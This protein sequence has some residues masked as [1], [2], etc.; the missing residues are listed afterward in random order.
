AAAVAYIAFNN[1]SQDAIDAANKVSA[2]TI[3]SQGETLRA[4]EG[5]LAIAK[6]AENSAVAHEQ[7]KG[8]LE[9]LD[10]AT[11][12]V[13]SSFKDEKAQLALINEEL[14][15]RVKNGK[16]V[17]EDQFRVLALGAAETVG[18]IKELKESI[19]SFQEEIQRI[20]EIRQTPSGSL[21]DFGSGDDIGKLSR[22][23]ADADAK[24]AQFQDSLKKIQTNLITN[25][26]A[27]KLNRDQFIELA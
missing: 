23:L 2:E 4:N 10:P 12:A 19:A 17:L 24:V 9:Q 5:F 13:V 11:R 18:K 22:G 25:A 20:Q 7:L 26:E 16:E 27:L 15:N 21:V 14:A 3:K 1:A 6:A 8:V